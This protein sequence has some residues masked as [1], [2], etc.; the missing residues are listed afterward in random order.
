MKATISFEFFPPKAQTAAIQLRDTA[1]ILAQLKPGFF[2]VTFGAGGSTHDGSLEIIRM[3]Q[4][5]TSI[6]VAPHLSCIGTSREYLLD[7]LRIYK[8][9]GLKR[10]VA[11]RGDLPHDSATP[12]GDLTY[13]SDLVA[14]IRKETGDYFHIEV[15]AYPEVHPQAI[16][17]AEDILNLKR[18]FDA[19]ANS[20][21]TQ[22]FFNPDA[23]FYF[24][25]ECAKQNIFSPIIPGIMPITQYS[26]LQRFSS[27]CGAEIPRW[28]CKRLEAYGDDHESIKAFGLEV[29]YNL[30]Q[31]LVAGGAP[32]LHFYT[33]NQAEACVTLLQM[34]GRSV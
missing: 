16:S 8:E 4:A 25:D 27:V 3:I 7:V 6:P 32:A 31:H 11:L 28:L 20:A 10:I 21:I 1:S 29:I 13:A 22:Y 15:A 9:M 23:Y 30:C 12:P 2:S 14:F 26:K 17:P 18:K 33:L 5:E 19:G 24:L 34:L